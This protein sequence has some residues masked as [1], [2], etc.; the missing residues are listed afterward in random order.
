MGGDTVA[1]IKQAEQI[2]VEYSASLG[3]IR[4]RTCCLSPG[5][6]VMTRSTLTAR[7]AAAA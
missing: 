2:L 1:M 6:A 7:R 3:R 4:T 5:L